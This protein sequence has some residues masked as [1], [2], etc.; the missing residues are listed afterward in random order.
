MRLQE[1]N[2]GAW[3]SLTRVYYPLVRTWCQRGHVP[4][5]DVPD[6]AQEVFRAVAA[7]IGRF[8]SAREDASFR[9]W[10]FG[11]ARRQL[12]TYWRKKSEEP[13]GEGGTAAIQ[14]MQELTDEDALLSSITD[15]VGDRAIVVRQVLEVI[16]SQV[17]EKTWQA[18]WQV[19]IEGRDPAEVAQALGMKV[20]TIYVV[21]GRMLRKLRDMLEGT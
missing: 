9:G 17:E 16:R 5:D 21:K 1:Q 20:A 3:S 19:A 6:V 13:A 4:L 14:R 2:A 8:D 11:I 18:F 7:G 10:L 15:Q 12:L